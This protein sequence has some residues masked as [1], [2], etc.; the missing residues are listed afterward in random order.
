MAKGIK[1]T[2]IHEKKQRRR[3]PRRNKRGP[4]NGYSLRVYRKEKLGGAK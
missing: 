2:V 3:T 1:R 4:T